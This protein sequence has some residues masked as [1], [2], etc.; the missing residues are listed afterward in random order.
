[1]KIGI[2]FTEAI[3]LKSADRTACLKDIRNNLGVNL[4]RVEIPLYLV[5]G[6]STRIA[7]VESLMADI[8]TVG[9]QPIVMLTHPQKPNPLMLAKVKAPTPAQMKAT[10]KTLAA[11]YPWVGFW[12]IFNEQNNEG[13]YPAGNPETFVPIMRA[14]YEGIK[15]SNTSTAVIC[16]GLASCK[17]VTNQTIFVPRF[18]FVMKIT[19]VDPVE[20][21]DRFIKAGGMEWCDIFAY[22]PYSVDDAMRPL[23]WAATNK[24]IAA[25]DAIRNMLNR[26]GKQLWATEYGYKIDGITETVQ[27]NFLAAHTMWLSTRCEVGVPYSYRDNVGGNYGMMDKN[28]VLRSVYTWFKAL[29][30]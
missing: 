2:N 16:G 3:L 28:N 5:L 27:S 20:W 24:Y 14:A 23:A 30:K 15:S 22:H 11:F 9:I 4:V 7:A 21:T 18:P 13:F 10:C 25:T 29:A 19:N 17:S 12:E 1:M 6:K 8:K 26:F